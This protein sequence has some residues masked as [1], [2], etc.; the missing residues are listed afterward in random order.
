MITAIILSGLIMLAGFYYVRNLIFESTRYRLQF[1]VREVL[2]EVENSMSN[3]TSFV[4]Q[5]ALDFNKA[6]LRQNPSKFMSMIFEGQT[7]AYALVVLESNLRERPG[8]TTIISICSVGETVKIA[9]NG[10]SIENKDIND[11]IKLMMIRS[12]PEWSSPFY[13]NQIKARVTILAYPFD[14][15]ANNLKIHS[16]IFCF[17]NLD[18]H[19]KEL[20]RQPNVKSG[21]AMLVNEKYQI[22]YHP[23][24]SQTGNNPELFTGVFG[25]SKL[26][27]NRI[28]FDHRSGYRFGYADS[29]NNRRK[30]VIYWPVLSNKWFMIMAIPENFFISDFGR[31]LLLLIP[32]LFFG[33]GVAASITIYKSYKYIAPI[34]SLAKDSHKIVEEDLAVQDK[35]TYPNYTQSLRHKRHSGFQIED[36]K[37]LASNIEKIRDRLATYRESSIKSSLDKKEI[38]N[39]LNLARDIEMG[40]IPTNFPL[41]AGRTDFDA[42]GKLIPARIV[43]GDLFDLFLLDKKQLFMSVTDTVGKGIPAAMYSVM[44]RTI[45]R[46]IASPGIGPG[47]MMESLNGALSLLHDSDM[48]ATVILGKLDLETGEF[49]Y[50]NAGHPHPFVLRNKNDDVTILESHGIPI[51]IKRNVTYP[52]NRILLAAGESIITYTDGITEQYDEDGTIYGIDRLINTSKQLREMPACTITNQLIDSLK[53]FQG[54]AEV[55]DD[56]T[57]LVVKFLG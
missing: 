39:E 54:N 23:D 21:F 10:I 56:K 9:K 37:L 50:C 32:L 14:Y 43:G 29:G 22:V 53:S 49:I 28:L 46:T 40:M 12:V 52:E 48:F 31:I 33:G 15:F 34:S 55:H 7:H 16:T 44:T 38:D 42:Y 30:V 45:I 13:D 20:I 35:L 8:Y 47:K 3:T 11:W 51:G 6:E 2:D 26:D 24:S 18:E 36:I 5:V 1:E 27:L 57:V 4:K 19:L 17:V 41:E 25:T